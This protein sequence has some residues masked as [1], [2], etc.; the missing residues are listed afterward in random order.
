[1]DGTGE[2]GGELGDELVD[3]VD[4]DD[5]VVATVTRHEMRANRLRH[6]AVFIA[7]VHPDGRLLAHRRSGIKDLWPGW[8]DIAVGGVVAAGET[9]RSAAQRELAEE[10]GVTDVDLVEIG[11]GSFADSDVD[12]LGRCY[13]V[14]HPGPF[15]FADGEVVEAR[16]LTPRALD[17][18]R[19]T[20][21]F[22]PD[23]LDVM[24]P[25]LR[26]PLDFRSLDHAAPQ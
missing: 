10:V 7:V 20:E 23:S 11:R 3:V 4:G 18:L 26:E 15:E 6:R 14:T 17:S 22:V 19:S 21:S 13:R 16:W 24:L 9:Y 25:L 1:M 12:L 2:R 8:W 5:V